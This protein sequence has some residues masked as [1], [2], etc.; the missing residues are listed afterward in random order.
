MT[1]GPGPSLASAPRIA[2]STSCRSA[3][4]AGRHPRPA[5]PPTGD[6][7]FTT[8]WHLHP[9]SGWSKIVAWLDATMKIAH[10]AFSLSAANLRDWHG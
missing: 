2:A 9:V 6:L 5:F 4:L 8:V 7:V 10:L 3:P 1:A